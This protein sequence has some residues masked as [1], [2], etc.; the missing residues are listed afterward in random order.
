MTKKKVKEV[1]E[2][3]K[4]ELELNV[5]VDFVGEVIGSVSKGEGVKPLLRDFHNE[6]L[7]E[8][9]DKINEV[10]AN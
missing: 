1:K 3:K 10:I 9:R 7:N 6:E 5:P 2:A 8:L 4:E